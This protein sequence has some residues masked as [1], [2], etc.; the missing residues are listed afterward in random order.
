MTVSA[1]Q[2]PHLTRLRHVVGDLCGLGVA[3]SLGSLGVT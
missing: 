2:S 1:N 3:G